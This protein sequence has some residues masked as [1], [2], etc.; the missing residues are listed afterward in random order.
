MNSIQV[1]YA[2]TVAGTEWG[3]GGEEGRRG[4]EGRR[5]EPGLG[6]P[7]TS[8]DSQDTGKKGQSGP[9]RL[10]LRKFHGEIMEG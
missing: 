9:F 4:G 8:A 2:L 10:V 3:E 5:G 6:A 7:W 1:N